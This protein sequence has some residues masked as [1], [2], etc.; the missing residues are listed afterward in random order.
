[1]KQV[2][3]FFDIFNKRF[4]SS[5]ELESWIEDMSRFVK[6]STPNSKTLLSLVVH[7]ENQFPQMIDRVEH[8]WFERIKKDI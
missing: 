3:S 1:M 7:F 2:W 6:R 4:L 8:D 5:Q